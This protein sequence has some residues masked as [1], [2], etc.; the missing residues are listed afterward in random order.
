MLSLQLL[1]CWLVKLIWRHS[2]LGIGLELHHAVNVTIEVF[3][4]PR[5]L[6]KV[7]TRHLLIELHTV[8]LSRHRVALEALH[9]CVR[10]IT[11]LLDVLLGVVGLW[12]HLHLKKLFE[13]TLEECLL[14]I[15][16]RVL[17]LPI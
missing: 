10:A 17:A 1:R 3:E 16:Q 5:L 9:L 11:S 13:L 15:V 2:T 6:G 8:L 14:I 12:H 4:R 7:S